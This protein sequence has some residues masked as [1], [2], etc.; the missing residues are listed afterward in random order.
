VCGSCLT[1]MLRQA[2]ELWRRA[3][4]ARLYAERWA[5]TPGSARRLRQRR[6]PHWVLAA[7]AASDSA[8]GERR[9]LRAGGC[10]DG[11]GLPSEGSSESSRWAAR[12]AGKRG[13][14]RADTQVH[15]SDVERDAA[16]DGIEDGGPI[17]TAEDL[18]VER[19]AP[20]DVVEDGVP[21]RGAE[22]LE[23]DACAHEQERGPEA[24][25]V[26]IEREFAALPGAFNDMAVH[27]FPRWAPDV[28]AMASSE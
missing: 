23:G 11:P 27:L 3:G 7:A 10:S 14:G 19:D 1:C 4:P 17:R 28:A 22:D 6:R 12:C 20:T 13:R 25:V 8:A 18:D 15:E 2:E 9:G 21:S 26:D 16:I 24:V 5:L